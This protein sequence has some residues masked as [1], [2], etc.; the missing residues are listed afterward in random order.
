M[1]PLHGFSP[2]DLP[3]TPTPGFVRKDKLHDAQ[4]KRFGGYKPKCE[5]CVYDCKQ[6]ND[7]SLIIRY[8][9]LGWW[10]EEE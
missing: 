2:S 10:T 1:K 7:P 6:Y 5:G 8:C 4:M 9:P 3:Y